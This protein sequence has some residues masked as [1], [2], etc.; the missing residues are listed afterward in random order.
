MHC[1]RA[2]SGADLLSAVSPCGITCSAYLRDRRL[3][4]H[5]THFSRHVRQQ[6][7]LLSRSGVDERFDRICRIF[8]GYFA[9]GG[10]RHGSCG[11]AVSLSRCTEDQDGHGYAG[12]FG[13]PR[14]GSPHGHRFEQGDPVHLCS[15]CLHGR[16]RRR[17]LLF[18]LQTDLF[19]LGL[20]ARH[21]GVQ[22]C[23]ARRHRQYSRRD[24]GRNDSW[25]FRSVR[26]FLSV[27]AHRRRLRRGI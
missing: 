24:G 7:P 5:S 13:R 15:R 9:T 21:Q 18:C 11:H 3:L 2:H 8:D 19:L 16:D 14:R 20:P 27:A 4:R 1:D 22:C 17:A 26:R 12:G 10:A 25:S 6:C 23:C